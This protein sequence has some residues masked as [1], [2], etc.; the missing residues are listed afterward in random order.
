[1]DPDLVC[2]CATLQR[3][4]DRMD[5]AVRLHQRV[6]RDDY[7]ADDR[8]LQEGLLERLRKASVVCD[9][10]VPKLE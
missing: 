7:V 6:D 5:V 8:K 3:K 1:M 4:A 10:R 9:T 2:I